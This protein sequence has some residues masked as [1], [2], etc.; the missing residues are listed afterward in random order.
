M[1]IVVRAVVDEA[2]TE[3][4]NHRG[5]QAAFLGAIESDGQLVARRRRSTYGAVPLVRAQR[6]PSRPPGAVPDRWARLAQPFVGR[7]EPV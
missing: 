4:L 2:L 5:E 6:W 1:D 3:H 7:L